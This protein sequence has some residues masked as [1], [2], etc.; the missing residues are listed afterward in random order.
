MFAH[1]GYAAVVGSRSHGACVCGQTLLS[2]PPGASHT[3][4]HAKTRHGSQLTTTQTDSSLL[5]EIY[6][7]V[8]NYKDFFNV[9]ELHLIKKKSAHQ[10]CIYVINNTV[11][12]VIL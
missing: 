10:G 8:Q 3:K 2:P 1:D 6:T 11:K 9:F 4:A 7:T 5:Q 12:N